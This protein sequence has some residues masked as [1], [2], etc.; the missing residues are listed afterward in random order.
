MGELFRLISGAKQ[1]KSRLKP[2]CLG[3]AARVTL[4]QPPMY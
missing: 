3:V 2:V 4:E 1:A